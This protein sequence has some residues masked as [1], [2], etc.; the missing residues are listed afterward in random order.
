MHGLSAY[1]RA[2]GTDI[3][4][5]RIFLHTHYAMSGTDMPS[6]VSA[7]ALH[8]AISGSVRNVWY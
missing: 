5:W 3:S 4:V 8:Y 2:L 7:Y 1:A 6:G